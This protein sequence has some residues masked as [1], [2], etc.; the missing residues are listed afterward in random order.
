MTSS[1]LARFSF[2]LAQW[3][4]F[5]PQVTHFQTWPRNH[6]DKHFEQ[7]SWWLLKSVTSRVLT[8]FP[9]VL[10][11]FCC[12]VVYSTRR[13]VLKFAWCCFL[14]VFFS[15][16]SIGITSLGEERELTLVLFVHSF[17]FCLFGFVCFLFLLVSGKGCGLWFWH[18]LDFSLTFFF[19]M[20]WPSDLVLHPMWSH[21]NLA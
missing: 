8:R 5:W 14:L 4:S 12:F 18:S 15:P 6:Q 21:L 17:D 9:G 1:L 16:L 13:F 2:D 11:T 10:L 20:I 3:P 19:P 7:H